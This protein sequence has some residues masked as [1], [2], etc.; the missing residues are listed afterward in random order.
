VTCLDSDL[1]NGDPPRPSCSDLTSLL[2]PPELPDGIDFRAGILAAPRRG[3]MLRGTATF[4]TMSLRHPISC[5]ICA[6]ELG[7]VK[8]SDRNNS[9]HQTPSGAR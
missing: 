5:V 7:T 4:L 2:P 9:T 1:S 3:G 6:M 8:L